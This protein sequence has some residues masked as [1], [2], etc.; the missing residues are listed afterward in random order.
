ML[1]QGAVPIVDDD[2][3]ADALFS[4]FGCLREPPCATVGDKPAAGEPGAGEPTAEEVLLGALRAEPLGM[5]ALR[6]LAQKHRPEG[7]C[8]TWL[9]VWLTKAQRDGL[10]AQYPDGRYGPWISAREGGVR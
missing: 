9:V 2:A 3:F 4:T 7:D 1:Y 6:G 8:L 10:I 5:E